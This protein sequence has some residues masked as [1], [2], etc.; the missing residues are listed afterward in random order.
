MAAA[1]VVGCQPTKPDTDKPPTEAKYKVGM[2]T[3]VGGLGDKGFNDAAYAALTQSKSELGAE[4]KA[5]SSKA[6]TDYDSNLAQLG[7]A[8]YD[9][10]VCVGGLMGDAMG[11]AAAAFP[12]AMFIGQDI[13]KEEYLSNEYGLVF[14]EQEAG[15]MA[16]IV[17]GMLT[18]D[19]TVDPRINADNVIGFVGGM[20]IPPVQRYEAGFRAGAK[21]VNPDVT[22]I[23]LYAG[24]GATAFND[25]AKGKEMGLSEISQKADVIFAAA[26]NTGLGTI[27]ACQEKGALFIGVDVDQFETVADS[28]DV[29]VTSAMKNMTDAIFEGIK[30]AKD[31]KF[32]GGTSKTFGI[33]EGA[34]ELAPW[35]D[36]DT[37]IPQSV[38]DAVEK[39]KKDLTEGTVTVPTDPTKA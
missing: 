13:E 4:I 22:I 2:V 29:M 31:G 33:K 9:V 28:G 15:Y 3:D 32:S 18:K 10:I 17:A 21:S 24:S 23:S 36:F 25:Q 34:I 7:N 37:K 12:N 30:A 20:P 39:A 6:M 26:G 16:G 19:T 1:F 27:K 35:H 11:K 38:K 8:E 5:V 14:K